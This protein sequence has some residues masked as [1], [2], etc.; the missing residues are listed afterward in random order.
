MVVQQAPV[1]DEARQAALKPVGVQAGTRQID[2]ITIGYAADVEH[3]LKGN[4][5]ANAV[6][7]QRREIDAIVDN[8]FNSRRE[9]DTGEVC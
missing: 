4:S 3:G 7:R 5:I 6:G 2:T 9:G 8:Q 1:D